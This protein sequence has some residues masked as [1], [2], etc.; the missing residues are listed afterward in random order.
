MPSLVSALSTS[1]GHI[2]EVARVRVL[3]PLRNHDTCPERVA[4]LTNSVTR[5][6]AAHFCRNTVGC[7]AMPASTLGVIHARRPDACPTRST[8]D[9]A[10]GWSR[11]PT[12]QAN[13]VFTPVRRTAIEV[14]DA[15]NARAILAAMADELTFHQAFFPQLWRSQ[16]SRPD[17]DPLEAVFMAPRFVVWC[18]LDDHR[19]LPITD[20]LAAIADDIA[21]EHRGQDG[22]I[23]GDAFPYV[24][25]P[26][27]AFRI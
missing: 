15:L 4:L 16:G 8:A 6:I 11:I 12:L 26:L 25:K 23:L 17:A 7:Y 5:S 27:P 3:L 19:A 18:R 2:R 9:F 13:V 10:T 24:T 22:P 20:Q 1:A 14:L 21:G